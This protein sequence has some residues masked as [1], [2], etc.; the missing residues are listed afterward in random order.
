MKTIQIDKFFDDPDSLRALA[1]SLDYRSR[2]SSEYWEGQRSAQLHTI[3]SSLHASVCSRIITEY[4]GYRAEHARYVAS[5]FF[6]KT[7]ASDT[8]DTQWLTDRVHTD[9]AILTGI[10]YL[11][12]D[13]PIS[14]GTQTYASIAGQYVPDIVMGN[15]Y[16]RL[17]VYPADQPHSAMALTGDSDR[18]LRLVLL[19]FLESISLV[20]QC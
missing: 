20:D 14:A 7:R 18:D 1:L 4:Y 8:L 11:T 19:F 10:V 15:R 16:N 5:T 6:H 17:V 13:A 2:S 3:N 12:P 9:S